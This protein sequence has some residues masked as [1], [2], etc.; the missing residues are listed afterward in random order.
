[1][2]TPDK[3]S[4]EKK[5]FW[6][7]IF[8]PE[9]DPYVKMMEN[10]FY[11]SFFLGAV[12]RLDIDKKLPRLEVLVPAP[13]IEDS[14]NPWPSVL[15]HIDRLTSALKQNGFQ[16]SAEH[17][18]FKNDAQ[19]DVLPEL[20]IRAHDTVKH[21]AAELLSRVQEYI[22][23]YMARYVKTKQFRGIKVRPFTRDELELLYSQL[24]RERELQ[25]GVPSSTNM[26]DQ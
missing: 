3:L 5:V 14:S 11:G 23:Y 7:T 12:P 9:S 1:M 19:L 8:R 16:V 2:A 18:M 24:K 22:G 25:A 15:P 6:E 26:L 21:W 20:I 10:V 17:S 13:T 4:Q